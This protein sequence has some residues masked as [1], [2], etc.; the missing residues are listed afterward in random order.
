MDGLFGLPNQIQYKRLTIILITLCRNK[1]DNVEQVLTLIY[2]ALRI[3]NMKKKKIIIN[4]VLPKLLK[5]KGL[6]AKEVSKLTGI[7]TS[8]LSTWTLPKAKP[9]N[10]E[11]VALVAEVLGTSLNFLLFGELDKPSDLNQIQGETVL[12]GVF[13][14]KL[15]RL[16]IPDKK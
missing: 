14:L 12:Q 4:E 9:R 3:N 7:S 2:L 1:F 8:T 15:E 11:D 5:D 16:M 6:T 10:I 13:R